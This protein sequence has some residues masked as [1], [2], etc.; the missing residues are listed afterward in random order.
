MWRRSIN[1]DS[2]STISHQ[3]D[4][5]W[6]GREQGGEKEKKNVKFVDD[7]QLPSKNSKKSKNRMINSSSGEMESPNKKPHVMNKVFGQHTAGAAK[8]IVSVQTK[9]EASLVIIEILLY[10]YVESM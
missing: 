3:S 4:Q 5:Y 8:R 1:V 7:Q 6:D 10:C 9:S 2:S